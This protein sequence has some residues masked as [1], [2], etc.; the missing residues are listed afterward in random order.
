MSSPYKALS[1]MIPKIAD[2]SV[3]TDMIVD[4]AVT[5]AKI[6]DGA[7]TT[8]K[9]AS[10]AVTNAKLANMA[11]STIKGRA[12]GAGTGDPTD[13]TASEVRTLLSLVVGTNVQAYDAELA[14]LAG[15]T[16]AANKVPRFTGSGTAEV[17]D[18]DYGTWTPTPA[19]LVNLDSA[20]SF[21]GYYIRVGTMVVG[22]LNVDADATAAASTTTT[23]EVAPPVASNFTGSGDAGGAG[24]V[25]TSPH[26][27]VEVLA[28]A[29]NDRIIVTWKSSSTANLRV[30]FIF[31]YIIR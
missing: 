24:V 15:L 1:W 5:T 30:R 2:D 8:A 6:D 27:P 21:A 20:S 7:V 19:G 11:E 29:A 25:S 14:A 23:F 26:V 28:S 16:S 12:A 4:E 17:I 3:T 13:L 18:V 10:D 9:V 31:F 22:T